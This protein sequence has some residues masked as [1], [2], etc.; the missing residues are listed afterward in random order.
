MHVLVTGGAGFIGS[1]L[2]TRLLRDGHRVTVLDDFSTGSRRNL[3]LAGLPA[4]HVVA[5]GINEPAASDA[6]TRLH[7]DVLVHLAAQVEVSR[8]MR[9]PLHNLET[10]VLG[11][12]R[13]LEAARRGG[14]HRVVLASSG[15]TIYGAGGDPHRPTA[16]TAERNPVSFYGLSK[17]AA[18]EYGRLFA[19]HFGMEVTSLALGNVYGPRQQPHG[20]S[21]VLAI[22]AH[23]LLTGRPCEITGDGS[24]VRDF[25]H[26]TDVADAFARA[27]HGGSG[28]INIGTGVGT[29]IRDAYALLAD[30]VPAA[31]PPVFRPRRPGEVGRIVLDP[32]RALRELGWRPVTPLPDGVADLLGRPRRRSRPPQQVQEVAG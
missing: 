8:S 29:S 30:Q 23:R 24:A 11:P 15:G 4:E 31:G 9:E 2:V 32:S 12:A 26:V 6:V 18:D 22:F 1:H 7:P 3:W 17:N 21:H 25:V 27:V 16:E 14:A 19:G 28:L 10:N 5:A 20:E 13:M